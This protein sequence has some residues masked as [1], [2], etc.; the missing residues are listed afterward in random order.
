MDEEDVG[1]IDR[2]RGHPRALQIIPDEFFWDCTDELGPFGSDEGDTA[3]GEYRDWR[4]EHPSAPLEECLAW[5]IESVGEIDVSDYTDA[6]FD[7]ANVRSQVE[8]EDFDDEQLIYV[9][10][11]SVIAT[12]FG[13]LADEGR[14]DASAKPLVARA[15]K[16]QIAWARVQRDWDKGI[17]YIARLA[18]LQAALAEA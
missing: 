5:T 2:E 17:E 4:R 7:V 18:R 3:L 15:L 14:I 10:D 11:V 9:T 6:I 13:Q 12:G 16:R 1:G 8:D